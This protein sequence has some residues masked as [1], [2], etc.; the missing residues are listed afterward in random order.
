MKLSGCTSR[1]YN[2]TA[3][4]MWK[5]SH[6]NKIINHKRHHKFII[7]IFASAS[8]L[9]HLF[10]TYDNKTKY[11]LMCGHANLFNWNNICPLSKSD[12]Y[13]AYILYDRTETYH[14]I[15]HKRIAQY[16]RFSIH[17]HTKCVVY[18]YHRWYYVDTD[19]CIKEEIIVLIWIYVRN[20][21]I[22]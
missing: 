21:I 17:A 18:V 1:C 10:S 2:N 11:N 12:Y 16:N 6:S 7:N 15:L 3:S 22:Q 5:Q 13:N 8:L 20:E 19:D 9:T 14:N 4:H